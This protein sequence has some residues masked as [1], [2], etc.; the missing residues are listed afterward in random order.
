MAA[1]I[2]EGKLWIQTSCW[3]GEGFGFFNLGTATIPR[4]EKLC[5]QSN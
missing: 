1:G 5:I 3:L 4:E 2:G